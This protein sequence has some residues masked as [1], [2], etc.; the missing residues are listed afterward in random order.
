MASIKPGFPTTRMRRM[1]R[2][3]WSRRASVEE[4]LEMAEG[5]L[6]V[7]EMDIMELIRATEEIFV[8][9]MCDRDGLPRW[10]H[11]RGWWP[12]W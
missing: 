6:Q 5:H 8:Y 10:T 7:P 1:R 9:P 2:D 12:I 4:A 11:G 3:D